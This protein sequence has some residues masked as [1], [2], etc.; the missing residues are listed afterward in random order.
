MRGRAGRKGLRRLAYARTPTLRQHSS[1]A[2]NRLVRSPRRSPT[3][4]GIAGL[5]PRPASPLRQAVGS[6]PG[7]ACPGSWA[8]VVGPER[9]AGAS[10]GP[11]RSG[12][13]R[14]CGRRLPRACTRSPRSRAPAARGSASHLSLPGRPREWFGDSEP[15]PPGPAPKPLVFPEMTHCGVSGR[16]G[17]LWAVRGCR[18]KSLM[19]R[20]AAAGSWRISPGWRRGRSC[21]RC[22][23]GVRQHVAPRGQAGER[24][25]FV[26]ATLT[27]EW[28]VW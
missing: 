26:L 5:N 18:S 11:Y 28:K 2:E 24:V 14:A 12:L 1:R 19:K 10:R 21:C 3:L 23:E 16:S 13:R 4:P 8:R 25:A 17:K 15:G 20:A 27:A 7:A 6:A 9:G 22:A